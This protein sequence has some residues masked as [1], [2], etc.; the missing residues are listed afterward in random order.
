M[1]VNVLAVDLGATSGRGIVFTFEEGAER[2]RKEIYRF[3]SVARTEGGKMYWDARALFGEVL[4][5]IGK[6]L[7]E[8]PSLDGIGIDSW[9]VDFGLLGRDGKLLTDPRC[10]RDRAHTAA[11]KAS[12]DRAFERYG[13]A[14]IADNDFNTTHQLETLVKEGFD[15]GKAES[16]LFIPQLVGYFLTGVKATEPTIASTCGFYDRRG[17]FDKGFL[18]ELAIPPEIF[19]DTKPTG[20]VLG[21]LKKDLKKALGADRDIPVILVPGH[22][23]A[24]AVKT[25]ENIASGSPLYLSSGTWSLFGTLLDEPVVTREAFIKG[26]TNELSAGGRIRFLKNI[27]GMWIIEECMRA[28]RKEG[29]N[30]SHEELIGLASEADCGDAYIDVNDGAFMQPGNMA[31]RVSEYVSVN[32]G[33]AL[34]SAG[35]T[36]LCVYRS[37]ARAYKEAYED[38]KNITGINFDKLYVVGGGSRNAFL[39]RLTEEEIGIPVVAVET[40][41]SALGN[42]LTQYSSL[43]PSN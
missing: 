19:P 8:Y 32:C 33:S 4:A 34:G 7:A 5:T 35:E 25:V 29:K 9:G 10:Y 41:A 6:A 42:A 17:G 31:D 23:T 27:M 16:L 15:F 39:N 11:R 24:C 37:M 3:P 2:A 30:F 14:G 1:A 43:I 38:L 36:A 26:Y 12:A 40:E 21:Y 22:D 28:W 13:I 20:S 18:E